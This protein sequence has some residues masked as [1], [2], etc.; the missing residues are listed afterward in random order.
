MCIR[1]SF[2]MSHLNLQDHP[3]V[4]YLKQEHIG[5]V[6]AQGLA[7]LYKEQ[8]KLPVDYLAK[9]LLNYSATQKYG[10]ELAHKEQ[11]RNVLIEKHNQ[12]QE[13]VAKLE[14]QKE[15][16]RQALLS[17]DSK[18]RKIVSDHKYHEELLEKELPNHIE[19]YKQLTGAYVGYNYFLRTKI[20]EDNGEEFGHLDPCLLYTSP[21]PRDRQKS[22]MP[23]SA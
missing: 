8:P 23:S 22:R 18:F 21:S 3:D 7:V 19:Q 13:F 16:E 6:I 20:N 2:N 10:Q 5:K 11:Q 4:G 9:W 17:R 12:L 15:Q 1:D 14:T